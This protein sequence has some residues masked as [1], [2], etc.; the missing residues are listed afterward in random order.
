MFVVP[1]RLSKAATGLLV[2][3]AAE[4][5]GGGDLWRS[6]PVELCEYYWSLVADSECGLKKAIIKES[7]CSLL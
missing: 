3:K 4:G 5:G 7:S 6:G 2:A 1:Q